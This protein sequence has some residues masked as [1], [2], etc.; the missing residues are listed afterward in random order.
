MIASTLPV[1][2]LA[3]LANGAKPQQ[4]IKVVTTAI[5]PL[6]FPIKKCSLLSNLPEFKT[7]PAITSP[8]KPA[9]IDPVNLEAFNL[10]LTDVSSEISVDNTCIS[11]HYYY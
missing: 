11:C 1:G 3:F 10:V 5:E 9:I 7:I 8:V 4:D 2:F 6:I